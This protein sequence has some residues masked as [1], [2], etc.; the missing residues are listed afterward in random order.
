MIGPEV[1]LN[2][3][4]LTL[5]MT[6]FIV[7][8]ISMTKVSVAEAKASLSALVN[9]AEAGETVEILRHGKPAARLVPVNAL[10]PIDFDWL[11][12]VT[13]TIPRTEAD[14]VIRLRKEDRY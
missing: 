10:E 14:G 2:P 4:I 1:I 5:Y 6:R 11:D 12:S 9:R 7:T 8:E 3:Q 13:S